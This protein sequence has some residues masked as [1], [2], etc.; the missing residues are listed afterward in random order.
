MNPAITIAVAQSHQQELRR[1]AAAARATSD[2]PNRTRFSRFGLTVPTIRVPKRQVRTVV[3][4][5][6]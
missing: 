2:L 5:G 4:P 6:V 1:A 3:N